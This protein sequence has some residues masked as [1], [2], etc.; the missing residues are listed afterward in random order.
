[1][2]FAVHGIDALPSSARMDRDGRR[3]TATKPVRKQQVLGSNP[4]VGSTYPTRDV[5]C[6]RC[7]QPSSRACQRAIATMDAMPHVA[8]DPARTLL[9]PVTTIGARYRLRLE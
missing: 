1:M 9:A 7:V 5:R 4:S 3:W 8:L 2:C 6:S